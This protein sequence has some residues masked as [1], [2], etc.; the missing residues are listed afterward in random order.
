M[1]R[2]RKRRQNTSAPH[3][4]STTNRTTTQRPN[5]W[6]DFLLGVN[7]TLY[8]LLCPLFLVSQLLL[9]KFCNFV[10]VL[11]NP[12]HRCL[13]LI[14]LNV[15]SNRAHFLSA[16]TPEFWIVQFVRGHRFDRNR[17]VAAL[18]FCAQRKAILSINFDIVR[19][20]IGTKD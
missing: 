16:E 4:P 3:S 8:V 15:V 6:T 7:R 9:K 19:G 18:P 20:S 5:R 14:V 17:L 11:G 13:R 10:V 2:G 12:Q 1:R